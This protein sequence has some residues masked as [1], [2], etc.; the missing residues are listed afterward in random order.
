MDAR[1]VDQ[2]PRAGVQPGGHLARELYMSL[3]RTFVLHVHV[4]GNIYEVLCVVGNGELM[5]NGLAWL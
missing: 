4:R 3:L 5:V 2:P 1:R